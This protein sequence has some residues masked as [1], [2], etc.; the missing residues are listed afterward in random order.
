MAA[1]Q[2]SIS[3]AFSQ[4]ALG[5]SWGSSGGWWRMSSWLQQLLCL[6]AS[7]LRTVS[8]G[9]QHHFNWHLQ[10][11]VTQLL[12][13]SLFWAL[14]SLLSLC[15]FLCQS[16]NVFYSFSHIISSTL[17]LSPHLYHRPPCMWMRVFF[18]SPAGSGCVARHMA[19]SCYSRLIS[20]GLADIKQR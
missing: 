16:A 14:L 2:A 18:R 10:F 12:K 5:D 11:R 17:S 20:G 9:Q 4:N 3:S 13:S 6:S 15:N 1:G 7:P 8:C 19:P